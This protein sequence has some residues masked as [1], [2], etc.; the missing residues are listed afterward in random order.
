MPD[1]SKPDKTPQ[2]FFPQTRWTVVRSAHESA[3]EEDRLR[4]LNTLC[5]SYRDPL[6]RFALSLG[7]S[8]EDA[9]DLTQGFLTQVVTRD[10]FGSTTPAKGRLRSFLLIAFKRFITNEWH[11]A[12]AAKRNYGEQ[13]LSLDADPEESGHAPEPADFRSPDTIFEKEWAL[14]IL[15]RVRVSLKESYEHEGKAAL[16]NAL[17][18]FLVGDTGG[19]SYAE[20]AE[21]FAMPEGTLKS[22]VF[23][24]RQRY[25]QLL[26]EEIAQTVEHPSEIDDELHYLRKVLAYAGKE[27]LGDSWR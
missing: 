24:M 7:K 16:G 5:L 9:E 12:R 2:G 23:R 20:V 15:H 26:R 11:K 13:A 22:H 14:H 6:Y 1:S 17:I 21:T 3:S 8:R 18:G 19:Q 4:A 27:T 25:K 10:L